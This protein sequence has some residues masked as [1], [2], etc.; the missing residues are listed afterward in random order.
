MARSLEGLRSMHVIILGCG[1]AGSRLAR[2][3]SSEGHSVAIIDKDPDAFHLLDSDFP[4]KKVT[5]VGFD[6]R[7]LI[8]AGIEKADAFV[9]LSSGDNS[10]IV[11]SVIAKDIFH[12]P[13]VVAR[14]YDPRRAV[15]FRRFGI[16]I[17]APVRWSVSKITDIL[18]M[19][20]LHT[21][22][23]FGGGEVEIIEMEVGSNLDG[24]VVRDFEAPGEVNIIC[25]ER[26]GEAFVPLGGTTL[27]KGDRIYVA[28]ARKSF[29]RFKRM[30]FVE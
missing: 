25:I 27:E 20:G 22:D 19:E 2:R 30:F 9:A 14:I 12:V 21:R 10:N 15:I 28:V 24:K 4:G 29:E 26:L 18:L 7:V 8:E 5:G 13:K 6:S 17:V 1:R 16:L 11:A 23:T 3:L